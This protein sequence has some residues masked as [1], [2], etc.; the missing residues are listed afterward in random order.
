[1]DLGV[2]VLSVTSA[3]LRGLRRIISVFIIVKVCYLRL[4][5]LGEREAPPHLFL[6]Q[7]VPAWQNA[8]TATMNCPP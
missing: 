7:E 3:P 5:S 4:S 2:L 6:A 8:P 1:M